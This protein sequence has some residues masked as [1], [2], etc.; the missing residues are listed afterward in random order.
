MADVTAQHLLLAQI[1][2]LMLLRRVVVALVNHRTAMVMSGLRRRH[3][4]AFQI[5]AQVFY[6][7]P[8]TAGLFGKVDFPVALILR[9]QVALPLFLIADM[10]EVRQL[11]GIDA[12]VAGT[13]QTDNG[14]APDGFNL[15]FFEEQMAPDAVF[16]IEAATGNGDV[17]VRML[18][19][20]RP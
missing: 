1:L 18:I 8:G 2:A 15:L 20:W 10:A 11:T 16:D 4:R 13:Q 12:I 19:G 17:D 5:T 14:T 3:R 9:L 6:A 7:A